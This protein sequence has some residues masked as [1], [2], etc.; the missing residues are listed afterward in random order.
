MDLPINT[1]IRAC[2]HCGAQIKKWRKYC[3]RPCF[4]AHQGTLSALPESAFWDRVRKTD[5]CWEFIGTITGGG[6]GHWK[7]MYA[8]RYAYELERGRILP[9]IHACHRCDNPAC[10]R[11]DHLFLGTHSDN[12][13]DKKLKGRAAAGDRS[14]LRKHPE[15]AERGTDRYCAKLNPDKV[16]EIR[17]LRAQGWTLMALGERYGVVYTTIL[18]LLR[19]RSWAH[20]PEDSGCH[21]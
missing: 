21:A 6:Y 20:V 3:S 17:A 15:R 18:K 4:H 2:L 1:T 8:H 11:P 12:M 16:R 19:G 5:N 14:G 10:V 9:G 13:L 7:G